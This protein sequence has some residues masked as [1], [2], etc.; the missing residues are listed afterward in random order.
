MLN[1]EFIHDQARRFAERL[2]R[3]SSDAT[4]QIELAFLMAFGRSATPAEVAEAIQYLEQARLAL[5]TAATPQVDLEALSS[6]LRVLLSSNE[7]M[8]VE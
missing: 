6:L 2:R 8:F 1:S 5:P 4:R 7:F 3:L